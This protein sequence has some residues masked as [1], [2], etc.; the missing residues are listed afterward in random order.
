MTFNIDIARDGYAKRVMTEDGP[1]EDWVEVFII[2]AD[3]PT[4]H[5]WALADEGFSIVASENEATVREVLAALDHDPATRPD[6][7]SVCNPC[8]GSDAW[9][10]EAEYELACFEADAYGEPRPRW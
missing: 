8:Y 5:R 2:M 7:W 4:G 9:D 10:N 3:A 1:V 6:L